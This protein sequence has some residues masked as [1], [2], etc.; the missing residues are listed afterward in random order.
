MNYDIHEC[1]QVAVPVF[2]PSMLE[3]NDFSKYIDKVEANGAHKIGLAKII[4]PVEWVA[5]RKGYNEF[6]SHESNMLIQNPI[7]QQ[8]EGKEGIYTQYNIQ[9]KHLCVSEYAA[10]SR[11]SRYAT[12]KHRDWS[13]LERKY[14]RLLSFIPPIY[15]A[16]ISGSLTDADQPAFNINKLGTILDDIE[17]E[18]NLKILG[19]NTAYLYFGMWK[20]SFAWHTED[21]DLYSINYL[22]FG[23]PKSWY[24][25]PPEHSQ[26]LERLAQGFFPDAARDC[27]AFLRH[28]MTI[29]SPKILQKYSI[30]FSKVTQEAGEFIITFPRAYHSGY[31]HGFNCAESTN[32]AM[33]RWIDFGKKATRCFCSGDTVQIKMDGFVKKYQPDQYDEWSTRNRDLSLIRENQIKRTAKSSP[34]KSL[35]PSKKLK[36][37]TNRSPTRSRKVDV[38]FKQGTKVIILVVGQSV[39]VAA[40]IVS[41]EHLYLMRVDWLD[42]TYSDDMLP[43]DFIGLDPSKIEQLP[44]LK[45]L[46]ANWDDGS[47]YECAF[48][49]FQKTFIYKL[50][51]G[52]NLQVHRAHKDVKACLKA[53]AC[54]AEKSLKKAACNAKTDKENC[55]L[56]NEPIMVTRNMT[57]IKKQHA[58][59]K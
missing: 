55:E 20:T 9:Q 26:R 30:P 21:M 40:T 1:H 2:R 25:V 41:Y 29:I 57:K 16:D 43:E 39:K 50:V 56:R 12:P 5:R 42:G 31:N 33:P 51:Y 14:W 32:F 45:N 4:P 15:G 36:T 37:S 35:S 22:H 48:L 11:T 52:D 8:V 47:V 44:R 19:V 17:G 53:E 58:L 13:E 54:T 24:V 27:P 34:K 10:L 38:P 28:K 7:S 59:S 3:F 23:A 6:E 49:S 46:K 18:Y